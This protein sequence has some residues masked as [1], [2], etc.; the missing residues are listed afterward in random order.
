MRHLTPVM[1]MGVPARMELLLVE[2]DDA[3]RALV[4][5]MFRRARKLTAG[6]TAV[7]LQR[8]TNLLEAERVLQAASPGSL[9]VLLDLSLA[10]A[11]EET[12][13][14]W[15]RRNAPLFPVIVLTGRDDD[16]FPEKALRAGAQDYLVKWDFDADALTRAILY[17]A[18]RHR[19]QDELRRAKDA[20]E[21]ASRAKSEFLANMSH[22][23]RTPLG[24]MLGA[25]EL[26]A[27]SSLAAEDR[28]HVEMLTKA[29]RHLRE[30]ID[31]VLDLAKV[32]AGGVVLERVG[33]AL[34]ELLGEV[35]GLLGPPA[36]AKALR[37]SCAAPAERL[38][39]RGDPTRLKQVLLNLVGN[40]IKFTDRGVVELRAER[41]GQEEAG[42]VRFSVS[43]TGIGIAPDQ[44]AR[45]FG[46]FTQADA[47]TTRLR[48]GT[49]LGLT[50]ARRLVTLMGGE[51]DVESTLGAG[52]RFS[53]TVAL[54][55]AERIQAA[56]RSPTDGW[57]SP[58]TAARRVLIADDARENRALFA[59]F[60]QDAPFELT[61]AT[62]GADALEQYGRLQPGVAI[63]DLH[64]PRLDGIEVAT[65]IRQAEAA[66]GRA[67][68]PL[69]ALTADAFN[70]TRARCFAAGFTAFLTKP[71][72]KAA[73][74][75]AI[76]EAL[77]T[78][79][80]AAPPDPGRLVEGPDPQVDQQLDE[81]LRDLLP[82]YLQN[83]LLDAEA[84]RGALDQRDLGRVA[85]LAHR[86]KGSGTTYGL[87]IVTEVGARLEE[88][89]QQGRA[90]LVP[91]ELERLGRELLRLRARLEPTPP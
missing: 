77:R 8:A 54:P 3:D 67:H 30:L 79:A 7:R 72:A 9:A 24:A 66:E 78:G 14:D 18:E 34:D 10:D 81:D 15:V 19:I 40:A 44:Q 4:D 12:T 16:A 1:A 84:I 63:L 22:E 21:A 39:V 42:L 56:A 86:M 11:T 58:S 36:R 32:E 49:G 52:S 50:I 35:E 76:A 26:L 2:D 62:D 80:R 47:S 55:V 61:F 69:I 23:I 48:G 57:A 53:F 41:V 33:F 65:R 73:L 64:M 6:S 5:G 46:A 29:G 60:L 74:R 20:A 70:Q 87:P 89:A 27:E 85:E 71:I 59:R 25:V 45:I 88:A 90:D 37:L 83:R 13:L 75:D 91:A 28:A 51:V 82:T 68:V 17:A 43:D 38:V 31:Q